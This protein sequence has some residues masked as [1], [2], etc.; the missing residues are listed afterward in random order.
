VD[1]FHSPTYNASFQTSKYL[2]YIS[3]CLFFVPTKVDL[4]PIT[5]L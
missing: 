5:H 2:V 4:I 3:F 1:Y